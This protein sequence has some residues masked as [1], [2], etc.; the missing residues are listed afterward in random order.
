MR[1]CRDIIEAHR[2]TLL[3]V[4]TRDTAEALAARYHI[5]DENL[6]VGVHHGSLS[7]ETPDR[8][9]GGVQA[10]EAEGTDLH[11]LAELGI[12]IGS[13][14]FAIQYNSP[15][16]VARL[17]QRMGRA[18]HKVGA[19]SE[20]AIIASSADEVAESLVITRK[21]LKESWSRCG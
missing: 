14:D 3:F 10:G 13:A 5:W 8:D 16:Q 21:A 9:G 6:A 18:G 4:N 7:K 20:G 15:R 19:R 17:I 12:D 1:R 2:S 11:L